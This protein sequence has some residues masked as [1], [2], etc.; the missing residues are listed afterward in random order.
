MLVGIT[1]IFTAVAASGDSAQFYYLPAVLIVFG[2]TLS[3][4]LIKFSL[5]QVINSLKVAAVA[6]TTHKEE[7]QE[8]IE[9]TKELAAV[10][11]KQ[12]ILAL[13]DVE[14]RNPFFRKALDLLVDGI[15]QQLVQKILREE[16]EREMERHETGQRIFRSIGD[17][18]PAFGMIGTLVGL[19]Q[20]L[21]NL[22]DPSTVGPGMAVALLTTLYGAVFAQLVAL[23]IAD[24][25]EM[26]SLNEYRNQSLIIDAVVCIHNRYNSRLVDELLSVYLPR[27]RRAAEMAKASGSQAGVS[28]SAPLDR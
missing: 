4:T 27:N 7:P 18:A 24:N 20:M 10:A 8:L 3:A 22:E 17:Q 25:L 12:G 26:R 2:G 1:I 16:L 23:P 9:Q 6:F 13:E 21:G 28:D 11:R 19:V 15:D 14:V 5:W